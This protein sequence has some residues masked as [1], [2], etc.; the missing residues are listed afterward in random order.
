MFP[1]C[2]RATDKQRRKRALEGRN[3]S[4]IDNIRQNGLA[5]LEDYEALDRLIQSTKDG[6]GGGDMEV[7][8]GNRSVLV[9]CS[10]LIQC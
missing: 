5:E 4:G 6:D 8:S 9:Q 7:S 1:L 10:V 2:P 3:G